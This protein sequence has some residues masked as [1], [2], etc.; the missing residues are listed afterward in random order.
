M[1]HNDTT[2]PS[3]GRQLGPRGR[4]SS[5]S[6]ECHVSQRRRSAFL[7]PGLPSRHSCPRHACSSCCLGIPARLLVSYRCGLVKRPGEAKILLPLLA[8]GACSM[9]GQFLHR[10]LVLRH[11]TILT[12][13]DAK[14]GRPWAH[15]QPQLPSRLNK[16]AANFPPIRPSARHCEP[17]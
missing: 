4:S 3:S 9:M 5:R 17:T 12:H 10:M 8:S 7:P 15:H 13:Y 2:V 11:S 6:R 1:H 16:Q 14:L